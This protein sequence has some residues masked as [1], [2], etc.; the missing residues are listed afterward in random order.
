MS[1]NFNGGAAAYV[2]RLDLADKGLGQSVLEYAKVSSEMAAA[3]SRG[4]GMTA[5]A[6]DKRRAELVLGRDYTEDFY[7]E[8]VRNLNVLA[9]KD[10]PATAT[11]R[12]DE[13][14]SYRAGNTQY[15]LV[16]HFVPRRHA[17]GLAMGETIIRTG[18]QPE[19]VMPPSM[20]DSF[21]SSVAGLH[22]ALGAI[23]GRQ[24]IM[25]SDASEFMSSQGGST[26][27]D[28]T[29]S[30]EVRISADESFQ[31]LVEQLTEAIRSQLPK[32]AGGS[33]KVGDKL[34]RRTVG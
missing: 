4:D 28:H 12:P 5:A 20:V 6:M 22:E 26:A 31:S 21:K 24:Q 33:G 17:G 15:D 11:T 7:R 23:N 32:Q 18:N 1:G 16:D 19:W 25:R 29:V 3:Q 13:K 10:A 8:A 9:R 14:F 34:F 2:Q 30:G 27:V